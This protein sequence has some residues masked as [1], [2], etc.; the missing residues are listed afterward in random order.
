[1]EPIVRSLAKLKIVWKD[2]ADAP[3][4]GH[5]TRFAPWALSRRR[6]N[7]IYTFF[8]SQ[9]RINDL[10]AT[11]AIKPIDALTYEV[12]TLDELFGPEWFL[13]VVSM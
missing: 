4:R 5:P 8:F 10:V 1:M 7:K 9:K 12:I 3:Y 13:Q 2:D 6:G 11:N